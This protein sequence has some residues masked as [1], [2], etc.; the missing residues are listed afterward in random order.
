MSQYLVK[1]FAILSLTQLNSVHFL[2]NSSAILTQLI[3]TLGLRSSR[4]SGLRT[5]SPSDF[6]FNLLGYARSS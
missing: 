3:N 6:L 1:V 5:L 4:K 2:V